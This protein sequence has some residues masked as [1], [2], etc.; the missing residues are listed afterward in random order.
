MGDK[1]QQPGALPVATP[2]METET[3]GIDDRDDAPLIEAAQRDRAAIAPLYRRYVTPVYRYVYSR[4]GNAQD[5]EDLTSQVFLEALRGLPRYHH[6]GTFAAWLFTIARR[7]ASN[8][9]RRQ[10]ILIEWDAALSASDEADPLTQVIHSA[11]LEQLRRMIARLD[12]RDQELLRLRYAAGLSFAQVAATL[13]KSEGA[14]KMALARLLERLQ[15]AFG[16]ES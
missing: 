8:H 13:G 6:H 10:P 15:R 7:R 12:E 14:V 9:F 4:V 3:P 1:M 16:G 11:D 5:T 2:A